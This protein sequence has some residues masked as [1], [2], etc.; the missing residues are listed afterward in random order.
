MTEV[1]YV[2]EEPFV[3]TPHEWMDLHEILNFKTTATAKAKALDGMVTDR[4][5][6]ALI[7]QELQQSL[8]AMTELEDFFRRSRA[9]LPNNANVS[10]E[11]NLAASA[12]ALYESQPEPHEVR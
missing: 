2:P 5:L 6:K 4:D 3:L 12:G 9:N 1:I 8:Q 7:Q 10:D 11:A